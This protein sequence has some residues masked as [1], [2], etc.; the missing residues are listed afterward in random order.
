MSVLTV[1]TT[2]E[3]Q[4]VLLELYCSDTE[5]SFTFIRDRPI[6]GNTGVGNLK[7]DH[8]TS[9][10]QGYLEGWTKLTNL[11]E[12]GFELEINYWTH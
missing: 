5:E 3:D 12:N 6:H 9:T 11:F 1:D 7:N 8:K 2:E 10:R 4:G